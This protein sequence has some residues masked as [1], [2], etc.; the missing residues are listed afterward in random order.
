MQHN[1][2]VSFPES[3]PPNCCGARAAGKAESVS[4][5][6][7][8]QIHLSLQQSSGRSDRLGWG[9][10]DSRSWHWCLFAGGGVELV[11]DLAVGWYKAWGGG[12]FAG[13]AQHWS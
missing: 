13:D 2:E 1:A 5:Q 12:R 4:C 6:P 8:T 10:G 7:V 11:W 9:D 3:H